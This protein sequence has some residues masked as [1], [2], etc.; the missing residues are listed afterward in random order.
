METKTD[1]KKEYYINPDNLVKKTHKWLD[2]IEPYARK[3]GKFI[4]NPRDSV[5]LIIDMQHFFLDPRSHAYIPAATT[6]VPNIKKLLYAY[7]EARLPIIFTRHALMEDEKPGIMGKWWNDVIK[8]EDPQSEIISELL[9]LENEIILRK[10]R[11]SA[12]FGTELEDILTIKMA[13]SIVICGVATHLCCE[14]TSREAFIKDF[15]VYFVVDSTAAQREELHVSSLRTL[16]NGF[17]VPITTSA[18][19]KKI[20]EK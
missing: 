6:I 5:L 7:R 16:S 17:A 19:I 9:P 15:E 14:T 1:S 3:D 10:T 18:I 20:Q 12:F 4:F 13:K 8:N 2:E 11:Y